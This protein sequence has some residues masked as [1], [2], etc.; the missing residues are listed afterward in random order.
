LPVVVDMK[1]D[2]DNDDSHQSPVIVGEEEEASCTSTVTSDGGLGEA[3]YGDKAA[4]R[5]KS[6][7]LQDIALVEFGSEP[8][9]GHVPPPSTNPLTSVSI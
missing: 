3:I 8:P 6:Y 2:M 7:T 5:W 4:A 1:R 9:P